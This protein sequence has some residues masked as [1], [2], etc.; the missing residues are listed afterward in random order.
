M[1]QRLP[2]T[3]TSTASG[4][5]AGRIA[6]VVGQLAGALVAADHEPVLPG[7]LARRRAVVVQAEKRPVVVAVA[8]GAFAG[9]HLLP[10]PRGDLPEQAG[11]PSR[12][13]RGRRVMLKARPGSL[14][15]APTPTCHMA[16]LVPPLVRTVTC[17]PTAG[18]VP[19]TMTLQTTARTWAS[20][21]LLV[22]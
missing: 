1:V 6:A 9:R 8:F 22:P 13:P 3:R 20:G 17:S 2:A 21:T 4:T 5:G 18:R 12:S 16:L 7:L 19:S 10:C 15:A 11:L 14:G